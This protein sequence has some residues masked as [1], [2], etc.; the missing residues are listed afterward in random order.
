M[1][2][3]GGDFEKKPEV[4]MGVVMSPTKIH[5]HAHIHCPHAHT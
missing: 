2:V 5:T 4:E 1:C 3:G